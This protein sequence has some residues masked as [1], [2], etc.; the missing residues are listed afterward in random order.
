MTIPTSTPK[1]FL[2]TLPKYILIS[3]SA[4]LT[5]LSMQAGFHFY[6]SLFGHTIAWTASLVFESLRFS[7]LYSILYLKGTKKAIGWLLYIFIALTCSFAAI[8]SFHAR[9]LQSQKNEQSMIQH[10]LQPQIDLVKS[11]Y[12]ARADSLLSLIDSD[13]KYCERK[14]AA[15]PTSQYWANRLDQIKQKKNQISTE[16]DSILTTAT[17]TDPV[18]WLSKHSA[19][20][21]VSL[22]FTD[23]QS[24]TFLIGSSIQQVIGLSEFKAKKLV[25]II[26]T[27]AVELGILLLALLSQ[28]IGTSDP[29][30]RKNIW[31]T[32][33]K[34]F[35]MNAIIRF[36]DSH[37]GYYLE[38]HTLPNNRHLSKVHRKI[39]K[40]LIAGDF[41]TEQFVGFF[42]DTGEFKSHVISGCDSE[43]A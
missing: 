32:L 5:F 15:D 41:S 1:P 34:Y 39:K 13:V 42:A 43:G 38:N 37:C 28:T 8:S 17:T 18:L 27:C 6:N 33:A 31:L 10:K 30:R 29:D 22:N 3:L 23:N 9:I 16:L 20:V 40:R 24:S 14:L 25:A 26:I 36:R 2:L 19:Q 21:G 4:G 35:D 7:T 12:V 11:R